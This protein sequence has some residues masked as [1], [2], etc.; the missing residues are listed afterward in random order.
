M[1]SAKWDGLDWTHDLPDRQAV[2]AGILRF[3]PLAVIQ[4]APGIHD[5][6]LRGRD[7]GLAGAIIFE[8]YTGTPPAHMLD[9]CL[10]AW[11]GF[12]DYVRASNDVACGL[13]LRA[14]EPI[15]AHHAAPPDRALGALRR[16]PEPADEPACQEAHAAAAG[17]MTHVLPGDAR[18]RDRALR[19][20]RAVHVPW[21]RG[22]PSWWW[23]GTR[24][25]TGRQ[26]RA[27]CR[28]GGCCSTD[29]Y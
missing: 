6:L 26:P 7:P 2:R 15:Y 23:V 24:P 12:R 21:Q 19:W 28:R 3:D 25:R 18:R 13:C 10:I 4:A 1:H 5:Q 11:L 20:R 27:A 14:R 8:E 16:A 22:G 17:S 29:R 9:G